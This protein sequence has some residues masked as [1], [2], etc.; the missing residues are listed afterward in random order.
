MQ[1]LSEIKNGSQQISY[2]NLNTYWMPE[3][4]YTY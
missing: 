1:K 4:G 2:L 3:I